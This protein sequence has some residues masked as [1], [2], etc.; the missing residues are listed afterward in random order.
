MK[1]IEIENI[2]Q[3]VAE[4]KALFVLGQ[5]IMPV[6]EDIFQFIVEM[7]P[8][9]EEINSSIKDSSSKMPKAADK[10]INIS[11]ATELATSEILDYVDEIFNI[12][13]N[14]NNRYKEQVDKQTRL[15][16]KLILHLQQLKEKNDGSGTEEALSLVK[17]L[18]KVSLDKKLI[19]E[20][21]NELEK[22]NI[23]ANKI[24]MTLQ[25]QDIT[26]QQLQAANYL[27][28]QVQS[29]LGNL[30][31]KLGDVEVETIVANP[32]EFNENANYTHDADRQ[33]MADELAEQFFSGDA[34]DD[35]INKAINDLENMN[36]DANENNGD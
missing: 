22:I 33:K 9:L 36:L 18:Y 8:V 28:A 35:E 24:L 34:S 17:K 31:S 14:L 10:I 3:R 6:L 20:N 4:V 21:K 12:N 25:F 29:K 5:K 23:F 7:N 13:E 32:Q 16:K 30:L 1:K 2:Q 27:I 15:F 11:N 19:D 26:S